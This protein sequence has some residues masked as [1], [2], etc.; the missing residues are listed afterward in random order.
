MVS[1]RMSYFFDS[2]IR[3]TCQQCGKCCTGEPGTVRVDFQE[4][5][6]IA[7]FLGISIHSLK[8]R[9]L[10]PYNDGLT[11]KEAPNGS[12]LFFDQGCR[13]YPVRPQ[14]CRSFPFWLKYMRST[15]AWKQ[16]AMA[17]PGIGQG[18]LYTREEILDILEWSPL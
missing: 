17:C 1:D 2:G 3:F 4:M 16:A 10:L 7:D 14:Q 5:V 15:Y 18:R 9:F 8:L 13:I 11:V 6:K 12:C